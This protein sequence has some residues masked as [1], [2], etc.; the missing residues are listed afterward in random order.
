MADTVWPVGGGPRLPS[1]G[2]AITNF[3]TSVKLLAEKLGLWMFMSVLYKPGSRPMLEAA[4]GEIVLHTNFTVNT[5]FGV[6]RT[7]RVSHGLV[8]A[9]LLTSPEETAV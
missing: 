4:D 8:A 5:D 7:V 1:C 2:V 3:S 9:L 6:G